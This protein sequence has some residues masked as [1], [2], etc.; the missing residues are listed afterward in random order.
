[1]LATAYLDQLAQ[2][3][4]LT[5]QQRHEVLSHFVNKNIGNY[6]LYRDE[7]DRRAQNVTSSGSDYLPFVKNQEHVLQAI[8]ERYKGK[9]VVF[10]FWGTWCVPCIG[11][12]EEMKPVKKRYKEDEE[13]VFVY[14]TNEYS[15]RKQWE[16]FVPA[17]NGEHYY[18]Y[19]EQQSEI[20]DQFGVQH[21]PSYVIFDKNGQMTQKKLGG[22]MGNDK[23]VEWIEEARRVTHIASIAL[24]QSTV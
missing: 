1:M 8:L 11:A 17:V 5:V 24:G 15:N 13:V 22:Y 10:D 4:P 18:L 6:L 14:V 23:L 16:H 9:I 20:S 2:E 3:E 7:M 12:F 19:N 21:I